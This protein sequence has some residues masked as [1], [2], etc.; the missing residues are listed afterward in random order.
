MELTREA[1]QYRPRH[2]AINRPR[3]YPAG[4]PTAA[5]AAQNTADADGFQVV[6]PRKIARRSSSVMPARR[7]RGR[8]PSIAVSMQHLAL[9]LSDTCLR[10]LSIT[11][12]QSWAWHAELLK[13]RSIN[14]ISP[15][16]PLSHISLSQAVSVLP[17]Q[18]KQ[19]CMPPEPLLR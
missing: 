2:F 16:N 10:S 15:S 13:E 11:T 19:Y 18:W 17:I 5:P 3:S 8:P 4:G 12:I 1:Y 7:G 9:L 14:R 6:R